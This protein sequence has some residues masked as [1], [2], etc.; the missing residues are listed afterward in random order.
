MK[1][2]EFNLQGASSLN[3]NALN[4]NFKNS[5]MMGYH[6]INYGNNAWRGTGKILY[7]NCSFPY[8]NSLDGF[9]KINHNTNNNKSGVAVVEIRDA[10]FENNAGVS[11]PYNLEISSVNYLPSYSN[12]GLKKKYFKIAHPARGENPLANQQFIL[13]FPEEAESIITRV[14]WFLPKNRLGSTSIVKFVL[15]DINGN[16]L[17]E[18]NPVRL[19]DGFDIY[20][21][22][23]I[24]VKN[25]PNGKIILKDLL[26]QSNQVANEFLCVI[27]YF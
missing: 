12:S 25:L 23:Y 5:V 1:H 16:I 26:N 19:K 21:D 27:E 24:N 20:D 15:T 8:R 7:E 14:K 3:F 13:N 11:S 4:V 18:I 22:V 17:S 6:E 2:F 9:I 10:I